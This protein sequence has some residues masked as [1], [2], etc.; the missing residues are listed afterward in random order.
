MHFN[1]HQ[2]IDPFIILTAFTL[3]GRRSAGAN[4]GCP[5]VRAGVHPGHQ[6]KGHSHLLLI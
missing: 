3:K 4:P 1:Q 6:S 2:I 5:W